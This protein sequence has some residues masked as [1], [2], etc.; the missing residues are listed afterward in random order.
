MVFKSRFA[1]ESYRVGD[2]RVKR[3]FAWLPF[4][5]GDDMVWLETYETKQYYDLREYVTADKKAYRV[6]EWVNISHRII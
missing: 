6:Y 5:I 4:R 3:T 1:H 2:T